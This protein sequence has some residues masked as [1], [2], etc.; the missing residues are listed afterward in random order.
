VG[1]Q[2][3]EELLRGCLPINAHK[4]KEIGMIDEVFE[5]ENYFEKLRSFT[6]E[7]VENEDKYDDFLYNK[8]DYLKE[9]REL[10]NACKENEIKVM[11]PEFWDKESLF[12]KLR[13]DFVYK[14]CPIQTPQRLKEI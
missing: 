2:M 1:A 14:V 10:I 9:N 11:Y 7:L 3:A 4:A 6:Q 8:Q 13:H 12:H 5:K